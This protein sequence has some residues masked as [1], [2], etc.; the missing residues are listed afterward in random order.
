[1]NAYA[2]LLRRDTFFVNPETDLKGLTKLFPNGELMGFPVV[3]TYHV[4]VGEIWF[5]LPR[6]DSGSGSR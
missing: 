3:T 1:M 6:G 2:D 4:P 5:W